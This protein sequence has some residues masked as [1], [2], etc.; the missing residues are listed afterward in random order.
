MKTIT[1]LILLV[2]FSLIVV[3]QE[4]Y[5]TPFEQQSNVTAT[6]EETIAFYEELAAD[7][8]E[9]RLI[10]VG[11]TDVGRPLHLA[12]LTT[13][14][15]FTPERSRVNGK[16]ILFINNAIHPGEACGVDASMMLVRDFLTDA[17]LKAQLKNLTVV[18][19]PFYNIG[20]GLNRNSTTRVNQDGPLSY[21]FRGNAQHLD[22]N[23]DFIKCDSRNAQSF[24]KIFTDW[25]P[26][27][28]IDNHTSN[29]ADYQYTISLIATQHNKLEPQMAEYMN[30]KMLPFLYDYMEEVDWEMT[31]YVYAADTPDKGIAGFLDLPR[32]S[33]GYAALHN[34]FGFMPETHM[35]K[36]FEDRVQSTY[37]FMRGMIKYMSRN[38]KNIQSVRKQAYQSLR[39]TTKF[40]INWELNLKKWD[41]L[42]FKGYEAKYKDSEISGKERLYYEREEPYE[43]SIRYY[44]YYNVSDSVRSP[45]AYIVPQAAYRVIERMKWNG[46]RMER[47]SEDTELTVDVYYIKNY[48][49]TDGPYEGH[50]LHSKVELES[51]TESVIFYKG[52]YV[53]YANQPANRYIVETLEPRAPDSFFAWNFFDGILERKEYFSP[54]LFEESAKEILEFNSGIKEELEAKKKEDKDFAKDG[55]AQLRFIYERSE[56]SERNYNRYPVGRLMN[57][58]L[59]ELE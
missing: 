51:E 56:H 50:Y 57:F 6:Y 7:F 11:Q 2:C 26:D 43:K 25:S 41:P 54:Y 19:I 8:E 9:L 4:N 24:N 58:E 23:R 39:N 30:E 42:V 36:P 55:I 53:I 49:T 32:Y 45:I 28:L 47:L 33:S 15:D 18:V 37:S 5:L 12:V 59:L 16:A 46:V 3:A 40:P 48:E 13:D 14:Q 21:G 27:V 17:T 34:T 20:G 44:N 1:T 35:L 22:L 38:Y 10:E 29:G 31:P 52:D